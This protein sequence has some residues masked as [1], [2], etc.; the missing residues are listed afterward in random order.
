MKIQ[1]KEWLIALV[2]GFLM[3]SLMFRV[4]E[5]L[6]VRVP[7]ELSFGEMTE[8]TEQTVQTQTK[9]NDVKNVW[10]Q[11][12]DGTV[13]AMNM[14][15]YIVGVVLGEM[16]TDFETEAL[17]AQAVV[18][19][20]FAWKGS[21]MGNKHAGGMICTDAACC[22]AYKAPADFLAAGGTQAR[23]DKVMTAVAQTAGQVLTYQGALIEATYFSCSGGRTEDAVAVWGTD[24]PYLQAVDSPGEEHAVH[25]TA[26][27]K[28]PASELAECLG[29]QPKG[30]PSSWV[31]DITYTDGGGVN[32]IKIGGSVFKGTAV[33]QKL[34]LRSTAFT[35]MAVGDTF[36][37]TTKGFGHRVGMSQY[38]AEAMAVAGS[39]YEEILAHYYPGT[40]LGKID[41]EGN[42]A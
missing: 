10:I 21:T 16:P 32:T 31:G 22:Q 24:V 9:P 19:R 4:A 36:L 7:P 13:K 34:G 39:S 29:I 42:L 40:E 6:I 38:G 1:H 41:R 20:T 11:M 8:A 35:I 3:P 2:I 5:K 12:A 27:V 33:R 23:L 14:D 17:K 26:L 30:S 25:F 37:I 28:I 15:T 18:A